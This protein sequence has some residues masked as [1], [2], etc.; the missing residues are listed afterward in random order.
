MLGGA[1]APAGPPI[2][3]TDIEIISS[4]EVEMEINT[5]W[6]VMDVLWDIEC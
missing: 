2:S 1:R 3:A 6:L 4:R 5:E